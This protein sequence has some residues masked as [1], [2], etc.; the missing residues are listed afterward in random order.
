MQ[1]TRPKP[2]IE[3]TW[4]SRMPLSA[5]LSMH[6]KKHEDARGTEQA[7]RESVGTGPWVLT[8]ATS[9][10]DRQFEAVSDHW[11][12]SPEFAEMIWHEIEEESTR[13]ANFF[14][15]QID[16][17]S[18]TLESI[19]AI[20][21]ENRD[22][23]KF[24]SFPG[25]VGLYVNLL[26]QQYYTDHPDHHPDANGDIRIPIVVN[27]FDCSFPW[28]SC[29]ADTTSAE[30]A[31]ARKVRQAM[32]HAIDR[33]K[34]INNLAFG[35][36]QPLY[37]IWFTGHTRRIKQFGLDKLT[38]EYDVAKSKALLAEVGLEEGFEIDMAL[39][40][41]ASPGAVEN[42]QAVCTMWLEINIEC[43]QQPRPYSEFRPTLVS[44]AAK[45][46]STQATIATF[47][48]LR[49]M[50]ILF[51]STNSI[52]F[53]LEHP[54]WQARLE[55]ALNTIDEEERWRKQADMARWL[56]D[57]ALTIVTYEANQVFPL[58]PEIDR[59]E[60]MAITL[61]WLSNFEYVPHRR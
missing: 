59:W 28:V 55:D 12:H 13:L 18:F 47:E 24:M 8:S 20:R 54:E 45:G 21:G 49:I 9:G 38:F 48:P 10:V 11:N 23:V 34:L 7:N 26:G 61:D 27:A 46:T 51:N 16:T 35:E 19:E 53:G 57:H 42:G 30:W 4:H 58:G 25:V 52:N 17:G 6:S 37:H 43:K 41:R 56:Y 60:P 44:R 3:T 29:D 2:T 32:N 39:T 1:L 5:S 15:G 14:V 50:Q 33:Q 22:A 31:E 40:Q 36:G